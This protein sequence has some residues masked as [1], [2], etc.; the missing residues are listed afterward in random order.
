MTFSTDKQTLSDLHI[1]GRNTDHSVFSLFNSTYTSGGADVLEEMFKNPL[2]EQSSINRRMNLIRFFAGHIFPFKAD[3]FDIVEQYLAEKDRRTRLV[4]QDRSFTER[5]GNLFSDNR[6]ERKVEEG[7]V[8]TLTIIQALQKFV[9]NLQ[10]DSPSVSLF[11]NEILETISS[12]GLVRL[13]LEN[14]MAEYKFDELVAIDNIF[15]FAHR[16]KV[17]RLL[18]YIYELDVYKTVGLVATRKN[19][20]FASIVAGDQ[21]KIVIE[22]VFHPLLKDA[23]PNDFSLDSQTNLLFLTGAN[24]AGKS[25]LMKSLGIAVYLAHMGFPVPAK[26]MECSVMDGLYTTIN[27]PDDLGAGSSH[28]YAEVL[29]IKKVAKELSHV[30]KLFVLIDELFRGTNVK[31][32]HDATLMI[33][34]A[35]ADCSESMF[36]ISTHIIEA[37]DEL[38][39]QSN[40]SFGYMP[41]TMDGNTPQYSYKMQE[42]ISDDRHGMLIINNEG[43][44]EI[45]KNGK[46]PKL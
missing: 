25:T 13:G 44:L 20:T 36:V 8:I 33:A 22:K 45:L 16:D 35:F 12:L 3:L 10:P 14:R 26:R 28:F 5:I 37:A 31:D 39:N 2:S 18:Q 9:F 27:L 46:R 32:A 24:M 30:K 4:I 42:G 15:R 38:G 1:F 34:S 6:V 11:L 40:I 23:R 29:R 7:A 21:Q 17:T 43:I 19:F 41:T